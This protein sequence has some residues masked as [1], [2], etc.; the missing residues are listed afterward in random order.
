MKHIKTY[1]RF[2]ENLGSPLLKLTDN[3]DKELISLIQEN[4]SQSASILEI[5]CGNAADSLHLKELGYDVICTDSNEEYVNNA[6]ILGLDC[7]KHDTTQNFPFKDSQFDLI[8]SRLGLHYFTESQL[9][10]ILSELK[11]IGKKILITVKIMDNISTGKVILS[12]EKWRELISQ[13]F[14][15]EHFEIKEGELYGSYSKWIEILASELKLNESFNYWMTNSQRTIIQSRWNLQFEDL[16][17]ILLE[18]SDLSMMRSECRIK[19][20]SHEIQARYVKDGQI[21][22]EKIP[23][24]IILANIKVKQEEY[25]SIISQIKKRLSLMN[26]HIEDST[27]EH[28]KTNV[29]KGIYNITWRLMLKSDYELINQKNVGIHRI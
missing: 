4:V 13:F 19:T 20:P 28:S 9:I 3:V 22:I 17:D 14:Q 21:T 11:R 2:F 10:S 1:V 12:P 29:E 24:L 26:L 25:E 15:I 5:S 7:I 6:I 18:L 27:F 23:E 8:Y 16:E